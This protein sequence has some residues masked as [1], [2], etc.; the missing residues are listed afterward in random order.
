MHALPLMAACALT[1]VACKSSDTGEA[2]TSTGGSASGIGSGPNGSSG[3]GGFSPTALEDA[4]LLRPDSEP[5][6]GLDAC[7]N[8]AGQLLPPSSVWN[9]P[10]DRA[11][12]DPESDAIIAY[13][14]RTHTDT[15]RF[16]IDLSFKVL[17]ADASVAHRAFIATDDFFEPDCDPAAPPIPEGGAI[18]GEQ[19]YACTSDGDCHLVVVDRDECRLFEMW[20]ADITP[21]GFY[22]GCQA[23]W[24]LTRI[25]GPE[26]RGAYCTSADAAGLPIAPLLF[27]ADEVFGGEIAHAVRFILPNAMIRSDSYV[28]PGT[29]STASTAGPLDAPPYGARLRLKADVDLTELPVAARVVA[30]A[31][32]RYGM[33]LA[34][35][36]NITFT[37]ASDSTTQHSWA[38][39]DLSTHD[40]KALTWADFEV[41]ESGERI[42]WSTGECQRTPISD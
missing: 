10:I 7:G 17:T 42:A 38:E 33:L 9:Q 22:G 5:A 1:H 20:R 14:S 31:L 30:T 8:A 13:L 26:G 16:Q 23:I 21:D 3:T 4:G 18:E 15:R 19:G 36:G 29:H 37:G 41:V 35:A 2:G 25:Y 24:D 32:K 11:A 39:L 40:L 28:A 34:D 6:S 27:T 12:L